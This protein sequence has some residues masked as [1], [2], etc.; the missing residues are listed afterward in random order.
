MYKTIGGNINKK[1]KP[2]PHEILPSGYGI[3]SDP[4]VN[5][6]NISNT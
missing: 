2:Q 6:S 3:N 4:T 1:M 5:V